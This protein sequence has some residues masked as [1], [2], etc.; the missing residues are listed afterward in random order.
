MLQIPPLA[1]SDSHPSS[2]YAA[3]S[4]GGGG[5]HAGEAKGARKPQKMNACNVGTARKPPRAAGVRRFPSRSVKKRANHSGPPPLRSKE[6]A[7]PQSSSP[8]KC[9][10]RLS[11]FCAADGRRGGGFR[12]HTPPP[13]ERGPVFVAISGDERATGTR[14]REFDR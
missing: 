7:I 5:W 11:G 1:A 2:S 12:L 10:F 4:R 6:P 13:E 9:I 8:W 14:E 3:P